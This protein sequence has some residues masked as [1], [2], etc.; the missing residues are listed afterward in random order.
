MFISIEF[1]FCHQQFYIIQWNLTLIAGKSYDNLRPL[2]VRAKTS[3]TII[4]ATCQ[5]ISSFS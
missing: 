5:A 2:E 1:V 3:L 4:S